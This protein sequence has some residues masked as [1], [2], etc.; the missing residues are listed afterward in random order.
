MKGRE[1]GDR[2]EVKESQI[3]RSAKCASP[4]NHQEDIGALTSGHPAILSH[5]VNQTQGDGSFQVHTSSPLRGEARSH[6]QFGDEK[7]IIK[8]ARLNIKYKLY[9]S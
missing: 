9:P 6:L 1:N 5:L 7:C 3:N 2:V 4:I 8:P